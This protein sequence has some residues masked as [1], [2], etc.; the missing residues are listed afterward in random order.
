R[1]A[2]RARERDYDALEARLCDAVIGRQG[3]HWSHRGFRS[4]PY[5]PALREQ[6]DALHRDLQA[7]ASDS[8]VDLAPLLR[9][10]LWP[11][12]VAY[13]AAKE[14]IGCL[15]FD[16]LLMRTRDL[17][18]RDTAVRGELQRRFTHF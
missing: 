12:V 14:K 3:K 11:V 16:D 7:F 1:R 5:T 18:R 13:E 2:G 15:D 17:L 6:R 4:S 10:E 9:D 8:G